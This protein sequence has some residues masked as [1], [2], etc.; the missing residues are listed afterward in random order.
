MP[1]STTDT[2]AQARTRLLSAMAECV[3]ET[4]YR[5]TTVADVVRVARMSRRSFYE[6]FAD[7]TACFIAVLRD[8][9]EQIIAS[10]ADAVDPASPWTTQV[11]DAVTA[12]VQASEE[13]PELTLSWIR[14]LPAL[15]DDAQAL[16]AEGI[17]AWTALFTQ[18][19][20]TPQVAAAGIEPISRPMAIMIWGGIRELTADSVETRTPLSDI[21]E[22]A[23]S[24]CIALLSGRSTP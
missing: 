9:N 20:S 24:A 7:K 2:D 3:V 10:V 4:G 18:I 21:I 6:H 14:E 22:P 8:A 13:H 17:E 16:K 5:A 12:Y 11:R 1:D 19:S 23:T 15:G